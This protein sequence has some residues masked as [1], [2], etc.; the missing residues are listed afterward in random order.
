[1]SEKV[2]RNF[3]NYATKREAFLAYEELEKNHK[4]PIWLH[5]DEDKIPFAT[6][7]DFH[8]WIWLPV[9]EDSQ[10]KESECVKKYLGR[11]FA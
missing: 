7:I 8:D 3:E 10:Y 5:G 11:V 4:T 1:M 6:V 9:N 2:K